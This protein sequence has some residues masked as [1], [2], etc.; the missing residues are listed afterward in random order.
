MAIEHCGVGTQA[1]L[2]RHA[3]GIQPLLTVEFMVADDAAHA[4]AENF[5]P[6]AGERVYSRK[7]HFFKR[8]ACGELG[9]LGEIADLEHRE[10]FYMNFGKPLL[11][12]SDQVQE[13]LKWQVGMESAHDVELRHRFRI[14]LRCGFPRFFKGHRV[15]TGRIFLSSEGAETTG[16]HADIR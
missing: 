14:S 6:A 8:L 1:K 12:S 11:E 5:G 10:C 16:S 3:R 7:L 9:T 4:I 13:I 2:V 15:G